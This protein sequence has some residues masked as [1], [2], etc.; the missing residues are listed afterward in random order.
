MLLMSNH[1]LSHKVIQ[2]RKIMPEAALVGQLQSAE[3]KSA[4]TAIVAKSKTMLGSGIFVPLPNNFLKTENKIMLNKPC[5]TIER[6]NGS[7]K[8]YGNGHDI[9]IISGFELTDK[10]RKEFDYYDNESLDNVSFFRYRG[11][12]YDMSEFERLDKNNPFYGKFDGHI[13]DSFFSG[14]LVKLSDDNET[15][16]AYT[17]IS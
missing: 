9:S 17:Y 6:D 13:S 2:S 11:N 7:I 1:G 16:K 14:V 3:S 8:I 4:Q 12:V 5:M 10:E 15:L